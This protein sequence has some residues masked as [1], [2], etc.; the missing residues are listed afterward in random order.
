MPLTLGLNGNHILA[1][2]PCDS[3]TLP[4]ITVYLSHIVNKVEAYG[5][6]TDRTHCYNCQRI[7]HIWVQYQ[8]PP[9]CLGMAMV[10]ESARKRQRS[11]QTE[12]CNCKT[13]HISGYIGCI[14]CSCA[15]QEQE[16]CR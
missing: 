3:G 16:D 1:H 12:C 5:A 15:K 8:Q 10:T 7:G 2:I 4:E 6:Q 14:G 13:Q 11:Q 9:G